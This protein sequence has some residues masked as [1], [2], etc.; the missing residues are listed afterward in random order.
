MG[1]ETAFKHNRGHRARITRCVAVTAAVVALLA[2]CPP[3]G[4]NDIRVTVST[5]GGNVHDLSRDE[6]IALARR[7]AE[8]WWYTSLPED[9]AREYLSRFEQAYPFITTHLVRGSTFDIVRRI[10]R[11]LARGEV[12]A[13]SVHVLDP[14]VFDDLRRRG[15]L[16]SHDS[17]HS[18]H[19]P[20]EYQEA[21]QWAAM[22]AV[23]ICISYDTS[24]L[25]ADEVPTTWRGLLDPKWR[26]RV[27]LKDAQTG[28][29]AYSQYYLLREEYGLSFWREM[30]AQQPRLYRSSADT[31]RALT[32]GSIDLAGGIL[33]Y[34]VY[35]AME[36]GMTVVPV[37]P[38]DGVPMTIGPLA[39]LSRAP[40]PHAAILFMDWA[41]SKEGQEA[42]V[43]ISGAY[44]V[45][46][47]VDPPP[48]RP[49][50]SEINV[51][52]QDG[53]WTEYRTRQDRLQSEY[54]RLFHPESE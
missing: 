47:D 11:E 48:G 52:A 33:G 30:A 25:S 13:D 12:R 26:G 29:S 21:G 3:P 51:L 28:G 42:I 37:W 40:H 54:S 6:I 35:G 16:Y 19:F 53:S 27:G 22:R 23:T 31:L 7:E 36:L 1:H 43:E 2:G 32:S 24:R 10:D 39:V 49:R 15:E 4:G 50:L 38:E 9:Q 5:G 20:P 18:R 14:A 8:V 17:E 44:S 41:L 46:D 45:R 34:S